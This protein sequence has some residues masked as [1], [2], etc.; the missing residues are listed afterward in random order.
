MGGETCNVDAPRSDCESATAEMTR[1][2]MTYVNSQYHQGVLAGWSTQGCMP[3]I[4]KRLGYRLV[5]E[6][7]RHSEQV[8]PGGRLRLEVALRNDGFASPLNV[9]PLRVVLDRGSER[10]VATL[11]NVDVRRWEAGEHQ[12]ATTLR[13][14]SEL[15]A[16]T[17]RVSLWLPDPA[18]E[19]RPEYA[20]A[21]ANTD[22]FDATSGLDVIVPAL[23]VDPNAPGEAITD[24]HDLVE[25]P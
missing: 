22:V 4:Q 24:A 20:I 15:A 8:K 6:S 10:Y 18:L 14:P 7:A 16:G 11:A 9:R 21:F 2:H 25:L 23:V 19:T 5:L 12:V 1:L 13:L 3:V 17:Y